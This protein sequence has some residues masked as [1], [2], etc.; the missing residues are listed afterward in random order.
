MDFWPEGGKGT[1]RQNARGERNKNSEKRPNKQPPM[2]VY[3]LT[4][5]IPHVQLE[6]LVLQG[7][8]VEALGWHNVMEVLIRKLLEDGGLACVVKAQHQNA[9]LFLGALQLL[10]QLEQ[11]HC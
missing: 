6:T 2:W 11:T 5:N 8:N 1:G 9:R 10:Q 3:V 4:S 7:L